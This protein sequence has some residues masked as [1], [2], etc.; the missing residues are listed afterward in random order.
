M[1]IYDYINLIELDEKLSKEL[2][3]LVISCNNAIAAN[4]Q[5]L[6]ACQAHAAE[7][8]QAMDADKEMVNY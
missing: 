8:R 2:D 5:A 4:Q 7:L 6:A 1:F 3:D